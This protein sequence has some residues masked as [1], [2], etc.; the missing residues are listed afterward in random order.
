MFPVWHLH[1]TKPR[2]FFIA[3]SK[4][5]H[6]SLKVFFY[7]RPINNV[8]SVAVS[9]MLAAPLSPNHRHRID[10]FGPLRGWGSSFSIPS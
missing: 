7:T 5:I 4:R 2:T 8:A 10:V 9:Y 3:R 6:Q 1:A